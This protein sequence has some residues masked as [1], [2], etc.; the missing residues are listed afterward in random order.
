MRDTRI[1]VEFVLGML[2]QGVPRDE[3]L[4][5]YPSLRAADLDACLSDATELVASERH[6]PLSA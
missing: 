6:F 4:D 5:E 1:S 2:A 3:I